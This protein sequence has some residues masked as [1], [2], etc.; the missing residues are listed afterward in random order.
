ME[1]LRTITPQ[2]MMITAFWEEQNVA[3]DQEPK[4]ANEYSMGAEQGI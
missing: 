2:W 4:N 3:F 1:L